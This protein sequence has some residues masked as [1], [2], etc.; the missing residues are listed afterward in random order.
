MPELPEVETTLR[1]IKDKILQQT[2]NSI[3]IRHSQLRWAVDKKQIL[4]LPNLVILSIKR[5][6]K[7]LLL[8]TLQGHI[9]IHLG[10][11]GNLRILP[12]GT[13]IKKHDHI[14]L[15]FNNGYLLRYHDP[16]RFGA[17][18]WFEGDIN[19]HPLLSKLGPEPL[20]DEFSGE[21]LFAK[22]RGRRVAIKN[23]IMNSH[24][25]V[26]AGNIYAS[27]SLFMSGIHP[28]KLA[29]CITLSEASKLVS[30]IKLVLQKSI[31][32]GGTTLKDFLSPDGT[33]GYFV[34][35]L[36]V[37]GRENLPCNTCKTP[38]QKVII[39]QRA[40]FFCPSCQKHTE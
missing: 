29:K 38:V 28:Q 39:N 36:K 20:T 3:E 16:R 27:E 18:L 34:Q 24:I 33:P 2:I 21:Y 40:S 4:T 5:R 37:Y 9:I 31:E 8:E 19:Q 26:G 13:P 10:M 6:G 12:H 30:N 25:V 15:I 7:Y 11:S 32:Q 14:D 22:T 23:L 35:K 17:W 1:G